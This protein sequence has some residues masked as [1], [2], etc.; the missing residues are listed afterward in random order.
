MMELFARCFGVM[1]FSKNSFET[2]AARPIE[3]HVVLLSLLFGGLFAGRL[4]S[5]Q[6]VLFFIVM[7]LA[8]GVG[9]IYASGYFLSWLIRLSGTPVSSDAIRM[10]IG[11][12]LTPFILGLLSIVLAERGLLPKM[13]AVNFT[14]IVLTWALHIYGI[15]AVSRIQWI[16]A[17]FVS[18][19]PILALMMVIAILFKV[20][21]MLYGY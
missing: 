2:V 10:V 20:A 18:V 14:L 1:T 7:G 15:K 6:N 9:Y 11:Y 13:S 5:E 12:S 19:I 21:G 4:V 16:Q 3:W 17:L 8:T